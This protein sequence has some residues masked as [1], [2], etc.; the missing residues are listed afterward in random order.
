MIH[1]V[2]RFFQVLFFPLRALVQSPGRMFSTG[3]RMFGVSLPA[4]VAVLVGFFLFICVV[5]SAIAFC[6]WR[7]A[8]FFAPF[9]QP[10]Y[11]TTVLTLVIVIPFVVYHVLRLWLEGDVSPFEDIKRAWVEGI[12][13]LERQGL[14]IAEIPLFLIL[15]S[16]G[17]QREKALFEAAGMSLNVREFPQGPRPLHWYANPDGIYLVCTDAGCLSRLAHVGKEAADDAQGGFIPPTPGPSGGAGIRGTIIAGS[18]GDQPGAGMAFSPEP[19]EPSAAGHGDIRGTMELG[20]GS[21]I[22]RGEPDSVTEGPGQKKPVVL[23][24]ADGNIQDRRLEYVCQLLRHARRPVC[25]VNGVLTLLPFGLIARGPREGVELQKALQRDVNTARHSLKIRCP[26]TAA[27]IGMEEEPGFQELVRRVGRDR[28]A[29]QRFGKGFSLSNPPIPERVEA[30]ALHAC[31]SFEAFVYALFREKGSLSKPG[32]TRLYSLLCKIRR[33]V[34]TRLGNILV[35]GFAADSEQDPGAEPFFFG[36][37]YFAAVGETED[38]QAF[39]RG[40]FDKMPDEEAELEW[41]QSALVED[42]RYQR[43]AHLVIGLDVLL[44]AALGWM[45]VYKMYF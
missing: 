18:E 12:G 24:P 27:V 32:N 7:D 14:D 1:Y 2:R 35:V 13:E 33:H 9:R 3:A 44:V 6:Y 37:C 30:L 15:G 16:D 34:Q 40:I 11:L 31:G 20:G 41:T 28:A 10:W 17:E 25:P 23:P 26:V 42:R 36:G 22:A 19:V 39:V 21:V 4:R 5:I 29:R 8:S 38:R 43:L 45:V